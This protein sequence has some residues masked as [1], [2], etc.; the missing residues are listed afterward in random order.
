[1]LFPQV[2][3]F[4][5]KVFYLLLKEKLATGILVNCLFADP[6]GLI[7]HVH[8]ISR[9]LFIFPEPPECEVS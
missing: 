9:F 4:Q 5:Q 3:N 7:E 2:I 6:Y 8:G 1:V